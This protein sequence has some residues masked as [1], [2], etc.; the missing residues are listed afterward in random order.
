MF[1]P[2]HEPGRCGADL[3]TT[4]PAKPAIYRHSATPVAK[5]GLGCQVVAHCWDPVGHAIVTHGYLFERLIQ[6]RQ[7]GV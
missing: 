1:P 7:R 2:Q 4:D 6:A 5:V 3:A